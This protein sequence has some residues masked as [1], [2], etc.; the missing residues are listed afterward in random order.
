MS[1]I[2]IRRAAPEDVEKLHWA[3]T[4]LSNDI[5]DNHAASASDLLRHG[6]CENPAFFAL[7]AEARDSGDVIGA[8]M[9]SPL[10]STT[11]AGIG[12]YVTDL[13]VALATRGTGLGRRLL[14][15][16]L[17]EADKDWT[18]RFLELAVYRD[19]DKA[20]AFYDRLGFSQFSDEIFLTLKGPD[21]A[22][23]RR[24]Q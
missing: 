22:A 15:A 2:V 12:L 5:D 14:A 6:F 18:V 23:L 17:T 9:A 4:Q 20:R 19:N 21:L 13:W 1:D 8:L 10:F 3:L 7:L 16:A 11:H 24:P